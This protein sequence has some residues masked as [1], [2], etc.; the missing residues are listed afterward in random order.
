M[1][2]QELRDKHAEFIYESFSVEKEGEKLEIAFRFSLSSDIVFSP[3]I[4]FP[5]KDHALS[6]SQIDNLAF[7]IGLIEMFSYWKLSCSPTITIKAGYLDDFQVKWWKKLLIS[8]M[9]EFFYVNSIDFTKK[10]FIKFDVVSNKQYEKIDSEVDNKLLVM[11]GGGKDSIVSLEALKINGEQV[12]AFMVNPTVAAKEITKQSKVDD[13]I[14]VTRKLDGK[15]L[16]LNDRGYLNGHTPFS[17][18][19]A[20]TGVFV[21]AVLGFSKIVTSNERS[22]NEGTVSYLGHEVN[23]QYSKSYEFENDF[24]D[25]SEKYLVNNIKYFSLLR[26]LYEIQISKAF[27]GYPDYFPIFKSCNVNS[28]LGSWCCECAK[29]LFVFSVLYP[30]ISEKNIQSI[31]GKNLF[32]NVALYPLVEELVG[33]TEKKPFECVGTREENKIAFYLGIMKAKRKGNQLPALLKLVEDKIM[34]KEEDMEERSE[35]I[36]NSWGEEHFLPSMLGERVKNLLS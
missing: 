31:F 13:S 24:R 23:H 16:E 36:M 30:F 10:D 11:V 12:S 29:C 26:P 32:D 4:S 17:A 3:K 25:Y 19:L 7:H 35:K 20:F 2:L 1:N 6:S 34:V 22:S 9:G 33:I 21:G 8:G 14:V 27:S 28:K 5:V 15:L 18:L